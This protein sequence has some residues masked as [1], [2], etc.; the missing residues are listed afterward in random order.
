MQW[1]YHELLEALTYYVYKHEKTDNKKSDKPV[2]SSLGAWL[3][4]EYGE[5]YGVRALYRELSWLDVLGSDGAHSSK[6]LVSIHRSLDRLVSMI[7]EPETSL[8]ARESNLLGHVL[9]TLFIQAQLVFVHM[10]DDPDTFSACAPVKT[11]IKIL[12]ALMKCNS[13]NP[14]KTGALATAK[15]VNDTL[16]YCVNVSLA[17][18]L[19]SLRSFLHTLPLLSSFLTFFFSQLGIHY[20]FQN[21]LVSICNELKTT[22]LKKA[23]ESPPGPAKPYIT[24]CEL[25]LIEIVNCSAFQQAFKPYFDFVGL[26]INTYF[27]IL[28]DQIKWILGGGE[29][30]KLIFD[31]NDCQ[32]LLHALWETEVAFFERI[33]GREKPELNLVDLAVLYFKQ[34][35]EDWT[36][37]WNER[38]QKAMLE[39]GEENW[40]PLD[41]ENGHKMSQYVVDVLTG[42]K[43]AGKQVTKLNQTINPTNNKNKVSPLPCVLGEHIGY[44]CINYVNQVINSFMKDLPLAKPQDLP[45]TFS[46]NSLMDVVGTTG[47][48]PWEEVFLLKT[49]KKVPKAK[50]DDLIEAVS[51]TSI[52]P[53]SFFL[54]PPS[55]LA[56]PALCSNQQCGFPASNRARC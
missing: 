10:F 20:H 11:A 1:D 37:K 46:F 27:T 32:E 8:V 2:I 41:P 34:W 22:R 33:P 50:V 21:T 24:F 26:S 39:G 51:N 3:F 54:P 45:P 17:F 25:L 29:D 6:A 30:G 56:L 18:L 19:P 36:N 23:D 7:Q 28:Y 16:S 43:E 9:D 13:I 14:S 47:P 44:I 35:G 5:R 31:L 15:S 42:F 48:L 4:E 40:G 52:Q 49:P 38:N 55:N 12:E 53:S